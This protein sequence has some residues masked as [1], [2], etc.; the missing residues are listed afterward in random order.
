MDDCCSNKQTELVQLAANAAQRRV[1]LMVLTINAVMFVVEPTA[2]LFAQSSSLQAD[3]VDMLGDALVY[4][5]SIFAMSR[6][7]KWQAGAALVKSV[8]I[9][10]FFLLIVGE[11][12]AKALHGVPPS[13]PLM[14]IFGAL[15]LAA[16]VTCLALLWRFRK[17]NINM[18]STFECSRNDVTANCGVLLA[19]G[20]VALFHSHG[21]TLLSAA[22][23]PAYF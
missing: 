9:L 4:G 6:G 16:N 11:I 23:L 15:A 21:R 22:L 8:A 14:M 10:G 18:R 12:I 5:L 20:G 2:G 17:L 3:A 13:S 1:L 7:A 19:A